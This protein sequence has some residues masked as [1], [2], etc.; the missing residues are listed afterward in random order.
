MVSIRQLVGVGLIAVGGFFDVFGLFAAPLGL[1]SWWPSG[2]KGWFWDG[3]GFVV[4]MVGAHLWY[5]PY[6]GSRT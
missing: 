1:I 6:G 3:V 4:W 5:H 2:I